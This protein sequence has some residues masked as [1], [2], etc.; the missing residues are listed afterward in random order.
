MNSYGCTPLHVACNN[1]QDVVV[2]VLLQHN[3][4]LNPLNNKG[5]V[6]T[7][8]C[9]CMSRVKSRK[10]T[11]CMLIVSL[12]HIVVINY[13]MHYLMNLCSLWLLDSITLCCLV[14]S[15]SSMHGAA[16]EV[17]SWPKHAGTYTSYVPLTLE[18][19]PSC[20]IKYSV[21]YT[22]LK[23]FWSVFQYWYTYNI[24]YCFYEAL[25]HT[26]IRY[27]IYMVMPS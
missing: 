24:V 3:A 27:V 1:G 20:Y 8:A 21:K 7:H 19:W 23:Y 16:G 5:Q 15:W 25:V 17:W 6:C 14:P 18:N 4:A 9:I 11:M 2:N 12:K 13:L 10:V 26:Y 22:Y